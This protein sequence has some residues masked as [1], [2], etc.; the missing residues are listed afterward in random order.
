MDA[1]SR[2]DWAKFA[3]AVAAIVGG[4]GTVT[5]TKVNQIEER[6]NSAATKIT[7]F[8]DDTHARLDKLEEQ[9][10]KLQEQAK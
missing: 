1:E 3:I 7:A 2:K 9:M 8:A 4:N 6:I 10:R 5:V